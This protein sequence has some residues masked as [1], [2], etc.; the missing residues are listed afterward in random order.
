M[1][2]PYNKNKNM[3]YLSLG[4]SCDAASQLK[5]RGWIQEHNFFDF[6]W[7]E[8]DGLFTVC[9]VLQADF[10]HLTDSDMYERTNT[11]EYLNWDYFYV[12]KLY[13]KIGFMHH[14]PTRPGTMESFQRKID[15]T[16]QLL[17]S[18]ED[19]VLIYYRHLCFA[20]I[21]KDIVKTLVQETEQFIDLMIARFHPNFKVISL[22]MI[23]DVDYDKDT[24]KT[25]IDT[26]Q[27]YNNKHVTYDYVYSCDDNA[28]WKEILDNT[29]E[30]HAVL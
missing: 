13:P 15:R 27:A 5:S 29:I 14:D 17:H 3:K 10:V 11:H 25:L 21:D 6:L 1:L 16:R 30:S 9:K 22:V 7:N 4:S 20:I 26:L 2:A 23:D 19:K 28:R 18:E 12:H 24:I 8:L